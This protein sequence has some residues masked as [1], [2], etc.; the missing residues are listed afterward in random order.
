MNDANDQDLLRELEF[1]RRH[2]ED[3]GQRI[4]RLQVERGQAQREAWRNHMIAKL[5]SQA[6]RFA[7]TAKSTAEIGRHVVSLVLGTTAFDLAMI[8]QRTADGRFAVLEALGSRPHSGGP[9]PF[10]HDP[11][12]RFLVN[13]ATPSGSPADELRRSI[14]MECLIW[15]YD[16]PTGYAFV[17][18]SNSEFYAQS[19]FDAEVVEVAASSLRVFIEVASRKDAER[20]L[21]ASEEQ[22]RAIFENAAVGI[23]LVDEEG[24]YL[25]ANGRFHALLGYH[26][27]ELVGA[28]MEDTNHPED[29]PAAR[30][31]LRWAWEGRPSPFPLEKRFVRKDGGMV[32][33]SVS[34]ALVRDSEGQPL[35]CVAVA[36]DV[37]QRKRAEDEL[38]QAKDQAERDSRAKSEFLASMS[39]ELRTPLNSIIGFSEMITAEM[40]GPV[41]VPR[42]LEYAGHI[43][44]SGLHLLDIV[45]DILDLAKIEAGHMELDETAIRLHPLVVSV[46]PLFSERAAHHRLTLTVEIPP[47]LPELW[48][49]ERSTKQMLLNLLSNAVKFTPLGGRITIGARLEADGTLAVSV[50]DTGIGIAEADI[51]KVMEPFGQ[52]SGTLGMNGGGTG[53]GLSVVKAKIELHGGNLRL[54][55]R[56][57]V[58]TTATLCFPA[59]R[60]RGAGDSP[61]D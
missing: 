25:R 40:F 27:G 55:S 51:E 1:Y 11:P 44:T 38:R 2:C 29:L 10:L 14:G 35:Y 41:G 39:H 6:Y 49:D 30:Q 24:H 50:A 52:S 4:M 58:G 32:W 48:A 46:L 33:G 56:I 9:F 59:W 16:P 43:H 36:E 57:G 17:L 42:Y 15:V 7:E 37:T 3:M 28:S 22:N 61:T 31:T 26:P 54:E 60:V 5:I 18:G 13:P 45:G 23:V 12:E 20:A 47:T 8:L 19:R 53:L 21:R 34:C